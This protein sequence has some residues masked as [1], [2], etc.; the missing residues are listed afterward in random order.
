MFLIRNGK[1]PAEE[2]LFNI[3]KVQIS[4]SYIG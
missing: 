4:V 1:T 3:F 2:L